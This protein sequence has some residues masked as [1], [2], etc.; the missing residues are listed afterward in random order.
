MRLLFLVLNI[1]EKEC[2][3]LVKRCVNEKVCYSKGVLFFKRCVTVK[4]MLFPKVC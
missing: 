3:Y 4:R 2:L 1:D